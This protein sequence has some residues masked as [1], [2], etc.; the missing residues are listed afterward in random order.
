MRHAVLDRRST[1]PN[2]IQSRQP[3]GRP[4]VVVVEQAVLAAALNVERRQIESALA[5]RAKEKI[6]QVVDDQHVVLLGY[7]RGEP[8][9]CQ[10]DIQR[11]ASFSES[12]D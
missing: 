4:K 6:T 10:I 1:S 12:M 3:I 7:L 8:L 9:E 11:R 5:R 2:G